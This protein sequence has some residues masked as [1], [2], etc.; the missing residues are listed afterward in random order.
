VSCRRLVAAGVGDPAVR[1]DALDPRGRRLRLLERRR[2]VD[3][4]GVEHDDVGR[5]A[6]ADLAAVDELNRRADRP[7]ILCTAV[8]SGN[9]LASR[10]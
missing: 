8:S 3:R 9:R 4:R 1:E 5:G 10:L 6:D 2:V 7:V